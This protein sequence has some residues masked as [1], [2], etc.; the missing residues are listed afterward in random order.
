MLM[1]NTVHEREPWPQRLDKGFRA[2]AL[3]R[4]PAAAFRAVKG[5]GRDDGVSGVGKRGVE[6]LNIGGAVRLVGERSCQTS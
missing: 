5:K 3:H 6:R 1:T 4:Q 2:V